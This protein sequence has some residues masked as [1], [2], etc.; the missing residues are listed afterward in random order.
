M[1]D[2]EKLTQQEQISFLESYIKEINRTIDEIT[3]GRDIPRDIRAIKLR[4]K[5]LEDEDSDK[6][7]ER[8]AK[9]NDDLAQLQE[10][11]TENEPIII[12]LQEERSL[13]R[14]VLDD[15]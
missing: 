3:G 8:I 11:W 14:N 6:F 9:L 1:L 4:I 5:V 13:Y 12:L 7:A 10:V 2:L 15:I